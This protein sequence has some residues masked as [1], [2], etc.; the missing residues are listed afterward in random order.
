MLD[1]ELRQ[2]GGEDSRACSLELLERL[3][4]VVGLDE[5]LRAGQDCV[6][7]AALV[8]GD[9]VREEARVDA[10][11]LGEPLDRLARGTG[12]PSLDLADVLLREALAGQVGLGQVRRDAELAQ[13]LAQAESGGLGLAVL[14]G[15]GARAHC[16]RM[17]VPQGKSNLH[18]TKLQ[19]VHS[20][21]PPKGAYEAVFR[22]NPR[23]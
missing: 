2:S 14:A 7:P 16:G 5:G 19:V 15:V 4:V 6:D 3:V 1:L 9:A 21:H 13:A 11:P 23:I 18:F 12:L 17:Q 8:G 20:G 22:V 10:Q